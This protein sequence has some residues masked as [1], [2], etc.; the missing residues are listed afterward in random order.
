MIRYDRVIVGAGSSGCVLTAQLSE[1]PQR[2]VLVLEA[3]TPDRFLWLHIPIGYGKTISGYADQ[4]HFTCDFWNRV[5]MTPQRFR[6][7]FCGN[8]MG[9]ASCPLTSTVSE[10]RGDRRPAMRQQFFD[11]AGWVCGQSLEDVAQVLIRVVPVELGR[12]NQAHRSSRTLA[13]A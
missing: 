11:A 1:D 5:G 9:K 10:G 12:L 3:G 4:P 8:R 13:T 6:S 7:E 2:K